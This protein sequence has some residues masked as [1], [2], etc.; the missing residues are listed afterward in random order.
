MKEEVTCQ[1]VP[2]TF[3]II[4]LGLK[5]GEESWHSALA[6]TGTRASQVSEQT[7]WRQA[8]KYFFVDMKATH[9]AR[10]GHAF[11]IES[12]AL[13]TRISLKADS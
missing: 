13:L 10:T 1:G 9:W 5:W 2:V 8:R 4:S 12:I 7:A 6:K 3:R 11:F